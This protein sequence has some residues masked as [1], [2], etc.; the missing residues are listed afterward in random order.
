MTGR[1]FFNGW[2]N[3]GL[4]YKSPIHRRVESSGIHPQQIF[5]RRINTRRL[6]FTWYSNIRHQRLLRTKM[7]YLTA[8]YKH[9]AHRAV[10]MLTLHELAQLG[11]RSY[12]GARLPISQGS[13]AGFPRRAVGEMLLHRGRWERRRW[14]QLSVAGDW[15][16]TAEWVPQPPFLWIFR[17]TIRIMADWRDLERLWQE[18]VANGTCKEKMHMIIITGTP[19]TRKFTSKCHNKNSMNILNSPT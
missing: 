12:T 7:K 19:N 10:R 1:F 13:G 18:A 15:R 2:K 6:G 17:L 16:E 9:G 3:N 8:S 14:R 11:I 5:P 4:I